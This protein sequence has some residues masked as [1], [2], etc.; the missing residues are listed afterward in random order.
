MLSKN[1]GMD[2]CPSTASIIKRKFQIA[3]FICNQGLPFTEIGPL[4][5][6]EEKHGVNLGTGCKND[7]TCAV[8]DEFI[9]QERGET[10]LDNVSKQRFL[11]I[12]TDGTTNKRVHRSIMWC[13]VILI[14]LI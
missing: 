2:G 5:G 12:Q 4:C 10:L 14:Q 8:F 13:I 1:T 7:S 9:V 11:S 3:Y 6:L